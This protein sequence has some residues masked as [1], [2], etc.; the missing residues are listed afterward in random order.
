MLET[1]AR[2]AAKA[3]SWQIIGFI[4]TSLFTYLITGS[5][6]EASGYALAMTTTALF[7][8]LIHERVWNSIAWGRSRAPDTLPLAPPAPTTN[9]VDTPAAG[10]PLG[11][12]SGI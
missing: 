2:S 4:A 7:V 3:I 11:H 1:R 10:S 5:L 8:Y 6:A 9:S 12:A